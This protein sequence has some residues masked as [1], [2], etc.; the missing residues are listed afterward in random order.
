MRT[1]EMAASIRALLGISLLLGT[2]CGGGTIGSSGGSERS[3]TGVI[4]GT[5]GRPIG[6]ALMELLPKLGS[7][8]ITASN[9]DA[10]GRFSMDASVGDS[11]ALRIQDNANVLELELPSLP[12]PPA[13][14]GLYVQGQNDLS[15]TDVR[16]HPQTDCDDLLSVGLIVRQTARPPA[17]RLCHI[18]L[19]I[20]DSDQQT[21]SRPVTAASR[22][23]NTV[24]W[25]TVTEFSVP[26]SGRVAVPISI[27]SVC[28]DYKITVN[29]SVPIEVL[30]LGKK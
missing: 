6:G 29:G 21:L 25:S 30:V 4:T 28:Q 3:F 23:C 2:G 5:D 24:A 18:S 10:A 12:P 9:T 22:P 19:E 16:I 1:V 8:P 20:S 26:N 7:N 14:I 13:K 17:D 15:R 27:G 11:A